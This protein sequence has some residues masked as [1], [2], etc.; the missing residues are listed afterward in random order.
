VVP[1]GD[2]LSAVRDLIKEQ[3]DSVVGL[4]IKE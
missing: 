2:Q 3:W 4:D 1:D